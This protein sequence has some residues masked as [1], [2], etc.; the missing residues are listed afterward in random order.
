MTIVM[1]VMMAAGNEVMV[2]LVMIVTVIA[3]LVV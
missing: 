3:E 1:V 2:G